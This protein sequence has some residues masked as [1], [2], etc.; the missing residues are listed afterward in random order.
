VGK[1][2]TFS[3]K[4][5]GW[6]NSTKYNETNYLLAFAYEINCS[7]EATLQ[8]ACYQKV[9]GLILLGIIKL[10][11]S[12]YFSEAKILGGLALRAYQR[13]SGRNLEFQ[14]C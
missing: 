4:T 5:C 6:F 8:V 3:K 1:G 10:T 2:L 11:T 7:S 9:V 14:L 13:V 12:Y